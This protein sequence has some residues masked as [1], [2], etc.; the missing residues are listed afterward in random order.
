KKWKPLIVDA[1]KRERKPY[2]KRA[3]ADPSRPKVRTKSLERHKK[4][5]KAG[6]HNHLSK[7]LPVTKS[8]KR[9]KSQNQPEYKEYLYGNKNSIVVEEYPIIV[10][11]DP[12]SNSVYCSTIAQ[13]VYVPDE[14]SAYAFYYPLYAYPDMADVDL[15]IRQQIEYYF[16]EINLQKDAYLRSKMDAHGF[17][18]L[19]LIAGFKRVKSLSLDEHVVRE[20]VKKSDKLELKH[21]AHTAQY[22]VRTR[23]DPLKWVDAAAAPAPNKTQPIDIKKTEA[24]FFPRLLSTSAPERDPIDWIQVRSKRDRPSKKEAEV[25]ERFQFDEEIATGAQSDSDFS[26]DSD[27]ELQA[28]FESGDEMDDHTVQKLLIIT[29]TPPASRK[30]VQQERPRAKITADLAQE[31]NDGLFFYEQDLASG[32]QDVVDKRVDLVSR[33]E[34]EAM[35]SS[36]SDETGSALRVGSL[37]NESVSLKQLMGHVSSIKSGK[38]R[39]FHARASENL[40]KSKRSKRYAG[41][42]TGQKSRFYP[43]VKEARPAEP[44]TPHKRKTRHS[45]NPPLEMHV[46]WVLDETVSTEERTR[47]RKS[48]H[49]ARSRHNST[50][51]M[52]NEEAPLSTSF[53]QS[54]DL[55]PFHH[56]SFTLLKQNGFAQQLYGKFRKR[57]LIERKKYGAGKS[58]EMNTLFRFWSFFL[59]DNFNRKMYEEFRQIATDDAKSGYR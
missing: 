43:V 22:F 40:K 7:T 28:E 36:E 19:A 26:A 39:Q 14:S 38:D 2:A 42:V 41:N 48:S 31:I 32:K 17:I 50:N 44:G 46:G 45:R 52:L 11:A 51:Y 6:Q 3:E 21:D 37:P 18:D 23:A 25:D 29:Q 35:K 49:T 10:S 13:P 55:I 33:Q 27:H 16:S 30:T 12:L 20:A 47:E 24:P 56:P 57:C 9:S 8:K 4:A 54:Q 1:P 59:R 34:F 58:Q 5:N 53:T 15:L